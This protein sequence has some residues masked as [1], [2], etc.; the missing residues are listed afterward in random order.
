MG[1]FLNKRAINVKSHFVSVHINLQAFGFSMDLFTF[2]QGRVDNYASSEN[3]ALRNSHIWILYC[4]NSNLKVHW[5]EFSE[6]ERQP[7]CPPIVFPMAA[8]TW[9]TAHHSVF[10]M[11]PVASPTP[12]RHSLNT[13]KACLN[14][15]SYQNVLC[16]NEETF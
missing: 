11:L 5:H 4:S 14:L 7:E 13:F 10:T 6:I 16:I 9:L 12:C 2:F 15:L 1:I 3:P 8:K